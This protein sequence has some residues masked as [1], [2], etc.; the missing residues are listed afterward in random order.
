MQGDASGN[1][2]IGI[3][4]RVA[5]LYG[6]DD[7]SLYVYSI[8]QTTGVLTSTAGSPTTTLFAPFNI[9]MQPST[10]NGEFIYSFSVNDSDTATNPIEGYSLNPSTGAL[11]LVAGSPFTLTTSTVFGE[12]DQS[13]NYLFIY[14]GAAPTASMGVVNVASTGALT[15]TLPTTPL[16]TGGY[17]AVSDLP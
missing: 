17:F 1:Y 6:F 2:L 9:A 15:E 10:V 12:F 8:D 5:Y 3:S 14:S 16:V 7:T 11:I 4:G 13:G